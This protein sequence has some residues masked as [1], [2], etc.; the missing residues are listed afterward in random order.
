MA[1]VVKNLRAVLELLDAL[2]EG[3]VRRKQYATK[4]ALF[5]LCG[6][7]RQSILAAV[8]QIRIFLSETVP[9]I[10]SHILNY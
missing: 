10:W 9:F 7:G 3:I 5:G 2:T 4:H 8:I 1:K 6:V